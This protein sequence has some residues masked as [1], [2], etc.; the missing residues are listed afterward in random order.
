VLVGVL[1]FTAAIFLLGR[2][3]ALFSRST[4]LSA[5]F[6]DISGLVV[7]APVRLAGLE[8][9]SVSAIS[10][11]P[12]LQDKRAHVRL[13]VQDRFMQRIRRDSEVF[14]DSAGLLGDK[15]VN[16]SMGSPGA[17]IL[18]DGDTLKTGQTV[19]FESLSTG[20]SQAVK[21]VANIAGAV[22]G[23]LTPERSQQ[24]Q[25]DLGRGAASLANILAEVEHGDGLLHRAVY[26]PRYADQLAA[27]LTEARAITEK[28]H[29]AT[30]RVDAIL[31]EV[32]HGPGTMHEIVYG[33]DGKR[34]L[35]SLNLA[36]SE[37]GDVVHE[38]KDGKGVLH[39]LVYEADQVAFLRDLNQLSAVL[40]RMAQDVDKGRGT[41]GGL[42]RD[43][44]VY[45]DL[46]TLLGNVKRNVLFKS[47]VR[48]TMENEQLRRV[49]LAPVVTPA[50]GAS[51]PAPAAP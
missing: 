13:S 39:A 36:A 4:E 43:P 14:I 27:I 50:N 24:L 46:K 6:K 7:G 9:G 47:L 49:E 5:N 35:A 8:V 48:F 18:K 38:V 17:P 22:E 21:S 29:R 15:V 26:D 32:E 37:I 2:K 28:A 34:A 19:T 10:F 40:T 1:M 25:T 12:D 51:H 45:E 11:P 3:S 33:S 23:V 41:L 44:S 16:I 42:L 31:A 30:G 20:L